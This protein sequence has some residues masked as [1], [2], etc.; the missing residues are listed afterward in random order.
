MHKGM[1]QPSLIMD[2]EYNDLVSKNSNQ[3]MLSHIDRV[4]LIIK[5]LSKLVSFVIFPN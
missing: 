5:L 1:W 4:K 3:E 2:L